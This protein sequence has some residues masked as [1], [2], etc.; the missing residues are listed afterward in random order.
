MHVERFWMSVRN[1]QGTTEQGNRPVTSLGGCLQDFLRSRELWQAE[2]VMKK[3]RLDDEAR[4]KLASALGSVSCRYF[5]FT[6][7]VYTRVGMWHGY[8]VLNN[9][10]LGYL[11]NLPVTQM[12]STTLS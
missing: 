1:H 3:F 10:E 9:P 7:E 11:P 8:G 5:S 2:D 4:R 12:T 6:T